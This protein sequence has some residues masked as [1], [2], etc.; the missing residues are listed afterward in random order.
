MPWPAPAGLRPTH[1]RLEPKA[2]PGHEPKPHW[3]CRDDFFNRPHQ[4]NENGSH[5]I[6]CDCH[7][8]KGG[9]LGSEEVDIEGKRAASVAETATMCNPHPLPLP[10]EGRGRGA[11][12][13]GP[14][15]RP[16]HITTNRTLPQRLQWNEPAQHA[17]RPQEPQRL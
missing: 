15:V 10:W 7:P 17:E 6:S 1:A 2:A 16:G 12:A 11:K 4:G 3:R 13:C 9:N 14:A 8:R 5:P